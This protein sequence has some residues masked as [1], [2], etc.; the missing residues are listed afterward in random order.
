M[1]GQ[2]E[3]GRAKWAPDKSLEAFLQPRV[4]NIPL[5]RLGTVEEVA[6]GIYYLASPLS[7][8]VTGQCLAIDGG[9]L[10]TI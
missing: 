4:A 10:R 8:Y 3:A 1:T 7:S 2:M 5:Q 9:G 6:Q